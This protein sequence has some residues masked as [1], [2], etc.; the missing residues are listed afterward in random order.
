GGTV[1]GFRRDV[2]L[3]LGGFKP[4]VLAEDTELTYRL[5]VKGWKV[6]YA[7][8]VEC[9]EEVPEDWSVRA[10]QIRRW[11][12]WHNQ[13]MFKHFSSVLRSPYLSFAEKLDGILLLFIYA[14]P[15]LLITGLLDSLALF[16]LNEM[17]IISSLIIFLFIAGYNT[18]GNFAP[19]YQ[20]GTALFLDNSTRRIRLLPVLLFSFFF[21]IWYVMLGFFDAILDVLAKRRAKWKK[22]PRAGEPV[23]VA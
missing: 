14:V 19:F 11:S 16:F 17:Q 9:Y 3:G 5:Y 12:R 1:G 18:F 20:V 15:L 22:T 4:D 7:N 21:N 6:V 10:N 13:A 23:S 8:R 2:V